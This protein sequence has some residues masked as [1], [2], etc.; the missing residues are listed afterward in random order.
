MR[1]GPVAWID[2][3]VEQHAGGT[4]TLL[5]RVERGRFAAVLERHGRLIE[6]A[7]RHHDRAIGWKQLFVFMVLDRSHAFLQRS[8]LGGESEHAAIGALVL[9]RLA[10]H[11]VIVVLVR[12]RTECAGLIG[13]VDSLALLHVAPL[14]GRQRLTGV[15]IDAPG[16]AI[17]VVNRH[18]DVTAEGMVAK[19]RNQ[20]EPWE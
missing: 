12:E 5:A 8:I 19:R 15:K 3:A 20:G 4:D 6:G 2:G 17:V 14:L 16:P 7:P 10:I 1:R 18:P 13:A 9:L 11:E